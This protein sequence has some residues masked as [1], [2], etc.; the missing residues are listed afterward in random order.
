MATLKIQVENGKIVWHNHTYVTDATDTYVLGNGWHVYVDRK[1]D[2]IVCHTEREYSTGVAKCHREFNLADGMVGLSGGDVRTRYAYFRS[3]MFQKFLDE[4]GIDAVKHQ[5]P[6]DN[7]TG[8]AAYP[9]AYISVKTD[10]KAE[11]SLEQSKI[12]D[13]AYF[14]T[15]TV[16][17]ATWTVVHVHNYYGDR[18]NDSC[19]LYTEVPDVMKLFN[20][21]QNA[22]YRGRLG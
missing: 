13:T 22:E 6:N 15:W 12:C 10:G 16:T 20:E 3:A 4:L 9:D 7:F 14:E 1:R 8:Y 5:N 11:S 21:I 18:R 17:G 19:I 2:K